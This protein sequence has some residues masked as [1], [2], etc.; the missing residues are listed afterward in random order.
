MKH[1]TRTWAAYGVALAVLGGV[2][3]LYLQPGLMIT[4]ADRVWACF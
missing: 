1:R 2:F 4:L 3:M